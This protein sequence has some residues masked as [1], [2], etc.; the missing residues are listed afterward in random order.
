MG[1]LYHIFYAKY[2][3]MANID[4]LIADF[5]G[6]HKSDYLEMQPYIQYLRAA[7]A[8]GVADV[9]VQNNRPVRR[10][11]G[12]IYKSVTEAAERNRIHRTAISKAIRKNHK[13]AGYCW[14]YLIS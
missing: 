8:L 5:V 14:K 10:G 2:K 11:D 1:L 6:V 9:Q 13:S 12:V 4:K 3:I 7:Y